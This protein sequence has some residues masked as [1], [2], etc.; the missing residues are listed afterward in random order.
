M[1]TAF[2]LDRSPVLV[3][4]D[5]PR[6]P[7]MPDT[8]AAT[9]RVTPT[10]VVHIVDPNEA[11]RGAV[12]SLLR[13]VSFEVEPF[14]SP[15]AFLQWRES[16][17]NGTRACTICEIRLPEMSGL[18]LL[19]KLRDRDPAAPVIL[20]SE[21]VDVE[22]AVRAMRAGALSVLRKPICEQQ[23][24]DVLNSNFRHRA[25]GRTSDL[26]SFLGEARARLTSRQ[27]DV[28]DC[29]MRGM[30][31][32]EVAHVLALSP[33][34]VEVYRAQILG[35]LEVT[36]VPQ[37][38]KQVLVLAVQQAPSAVRPPDTAEQEF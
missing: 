37:L 17:P 11:S 4:A 38:L 10:W 2:T 3:A 8:A 27:C 18:A 32:K 29:L 33:R 16:A 34:T 1:P 26:S 22:T 21:H 19:Q 28:F 30:Q 35:R 20:V 24:I 31:T 5:D 12:A 6:R 15:G 9:P 25:V 36:S 14:S 23:L 7:S 13:S